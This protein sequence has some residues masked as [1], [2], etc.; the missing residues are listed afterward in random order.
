MSVES[1]EDMG[2]PRAGITDGCEL[3]CG[4]WELSVGV[5]EEQSVFH[6]LSHWTIPLVNGKMSGIITD[7]TKI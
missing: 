5:L 4:C 7:K 1:E 3:T 2:S 6:T